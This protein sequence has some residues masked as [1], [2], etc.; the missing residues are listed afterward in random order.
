MTYHLYPA[1]PPWYFHQYGCVVDLAAPASA[2]P[3]L[4]R[5]DALL[6]VPYFAGVY[7]RA[8]DVF[9]AVPSLHVAY[10]MLMIAVGWPV[11][12]VLGRALLVL[13][14][15]WMC[16]SAIYLDHHWVVDVVAGASYALVVAFGVRRWGSRKFAGG[17]RRTLAL[18][19]APDPSRSIG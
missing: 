2:G 13:F 3:N 15:G 4:T 1:A 6:G 7:G 14:F 12:R 16:F 10:P 8:S 11:H 5:V 9:G 19:S 18:D 17:E